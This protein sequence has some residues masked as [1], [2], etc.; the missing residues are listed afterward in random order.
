MPYPPAHAFDQTV[1]ATALEPA[2]NTIAG[3]TGNAHTIMGTVPG[4]SPTA[5]PMPPYDVQ[6]L[7]NVTDESGNQLTDESGLEL[8]DE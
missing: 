6:A 1:P 4:L 8:I 7:Y 5:Q 2:I 3:G